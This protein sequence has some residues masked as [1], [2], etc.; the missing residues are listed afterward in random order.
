MNKKQSHITYEGQPAQNAKNDV[1]GG[2][3]VRIDEKSQA[4]YLK[5]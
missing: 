1:F 2:K 5:S 3:G 4:S